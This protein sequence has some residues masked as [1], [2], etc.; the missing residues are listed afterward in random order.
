MVAPG[1]VSFHFTGEGVRWPNGD[2]L[3]RV[4]IQPDVRIEPDAADIAAGNDVVLQKGLDEA[5]RLAGGTSAERNTAVGRERVREHAAFNAPPSAQSFEAKGTKAQPLALDWSSKAAG[6]RGWTAPVGGYADSAELSLSSVPNTA[7]GASYGS[8]TGRLDITDYRGKTVRIR[9]YLS[10][11]NVTTGA[12]FWLR[13]DGPSQ[14]FDNMQD[15]WLVGSNGWMPFAIV[16]HVPTS[17]T[18][19]YCG[20]LLV[21]PGTAHASAL[22]IDVVPDATLVTGS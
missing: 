21:G 17:A 9:G 22:T 13:I 20:L 1:A 2:Q 4:G 15:R 7:Q 16:L 8:Y 3:Q 12:G 14:Q 6:Y 18:Q 19:G 10:T 11:E 5:L